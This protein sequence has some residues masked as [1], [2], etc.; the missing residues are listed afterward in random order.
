MTVNPS[1]RALPGGPPHG[2]RLGPT[3]DARPAITSHYSRWPNIGRQAFRPMGLRKVH[4]DQIGC[5]EAP[6]GPARVGCVL[7]V[8]SWSQYYR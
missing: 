2:P 8:T 7:N 6:K 3:R 5:A 4:S 1:V